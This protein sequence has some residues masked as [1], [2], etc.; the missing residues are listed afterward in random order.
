MRGFNGVFNSKN[1]KKGRTVELRRGY[2]DNPIWGIITDRLIIKSLNEIPKEIYD[3]TIPPS[4]QNDPKVIDFVQDYVKKYEKLILFK[5]QL[6][7]D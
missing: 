4:V 5:I 6:K 3:K 1:V 7:K 2:K